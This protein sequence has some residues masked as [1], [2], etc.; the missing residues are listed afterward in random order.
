MRV[1]LRYGKKF[2]YW[3]DASR[4][5]TVLE[6]RGPAH[7]PTLAQTQILGGDFDRFL[8]G[9]KNL[10]VV[11][12]DVTRPCGLR[13]FFHVILRRAEAS[14]IPESKVTVLFA[15]GLHRE[16]RGTE[17]KQILGILGHTDCSLLNHSSRDAASMGFAGLSASGIRVEINRAIL[18]ADR[19]LLTGAVGFHYLAGYSGGWK[20]VVPGVA[21]TETILAFHKLTLD[22][23]D[24]VGPG[25]TDG[26]P[27]Y[28]EISAL[29]GLL[30]DR[31]FLVNT[32]LS[33]DGRLIGA[34]SGN[35]ETAHRQ[36]GEFYRKLYAVPIEN[37]AD[38]A[39]VSCGGF[40][41]DIN[42]IQ[43]HKA[44]EAGARAVNPG[45]TLILLAECGDGF[46]H[47]QF[48]QWFSHK[49]SSSLFN[50]LKDQFHVYGRTAWCILKK[51]ETYK[52]ILVSSFKTQDLQPMG[53]TAC[54]SLKDALYYSRKMLPRVQPFYLVPEGSWVL[55][56]PSAKNG[57]PF[58]AS[59][60]GS[61]RSPSLGA[62]PILT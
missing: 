46:G 24:R 50:H 38:L 48:L 59:P 19:V 57:D 36:G 60:G 51:S 18:E 22:R 37:K 14:G 54:G 44:L 15:N 33:P 10:L 56:S 32:V 4:P 47:P 26:N 62:P 40:P 11:A 43:S 9:G 27:F 25:V 31:F 28:S 39:I 6:A 17:M 30:K 61:G 21:S 52:I 55:P 58:P 29:G 13:T 3:Q 8:A 20:I 42:L 49:N 16:L 1:K 12:P 2:F 53:I 7:M 35:V 23:D 34:F 45:G 41:K 5:A